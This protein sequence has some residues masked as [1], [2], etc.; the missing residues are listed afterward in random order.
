MNCGPAKH[1]F[2]D[3]IFSMDIYNFDGEID[4][5]KLKKFQMLKKV[6]SRTN[7][8]FDQILNEIN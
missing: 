8:E 3:A 5:K 4:Q 1:A 6:E 7:E 2:Y